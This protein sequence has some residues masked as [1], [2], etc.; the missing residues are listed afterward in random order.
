MFTL[1]GK[2][3]GTLDEAGLQFPISH[4]GPKAMLVPFFG[5]RYSSIPRCGNT[6]CEAK[7]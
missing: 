5:K 2:V 6:T 1:F 3:I 4:F 7:W